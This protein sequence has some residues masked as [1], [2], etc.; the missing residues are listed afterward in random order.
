M[1]ATMTLICMIGMIGIIGIIRI[2]GR[3]LNNTFG[4]VQKQDVCGF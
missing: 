4:H 3:D 1:L 2:P